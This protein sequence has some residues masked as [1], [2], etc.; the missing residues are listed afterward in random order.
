MA[1]ALIFVAFY[2]ENAQGLKRNRTERITRLHFYMHDVVFGPNATVALVASPS[3][4]F[5]SP[6]FGNVFVIDDV[7]TAGPSPYSRVVGRA[8]GM[9]IADSLKEPS[10]M[11]L[12]TVVL[13]SGKHNGSTI[14]IQGADRAILPLR[15]VSVVGGTGR[16]RFARGYAGIMTHSLNPSTAVLKFN[17]TLLH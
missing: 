1:I 17:V 7:L 15:E 14:S 6:G 2:P 12:F 4:N 5:T 9:Y 11:L 3:G 13:Q 8:Q 10:L 16:F